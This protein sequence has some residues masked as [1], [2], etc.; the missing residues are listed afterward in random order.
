MAVKNRSR[1]E[2]EYKKPISSSAIVWR[3]NFSLGA[4]HLMLNLYLIFLL[5]LFFLPANP[6]WG[7]TALLVAALSNPFWSLIH[8]AV[9][10]M[11]H[12]SH[13]INMAAG[14]ILGIF[15]GGP[16]LV[17]RT[18]HL[19][20]H[21]LN[22]SPLEGTELYDPAQTS[23][24]RAGVGYYFQILSGLYLLE[25][26]SSLFFLLPRTI[27]LRMQERLNRKKSLSG[28][29]L[30]SLMRN[31]L[32]SE[33]R[34]DGIAILVLLGLSAFCYGKHWPWLVGALILRA[35]LI[36]FLDNVYH[37][38]TPVDDVFYA[39]NLWLP[40]GLSNVLL[41]F[42]LHGVHHGNTSIPWIELP[43]VFR[44]QSKSYDGNY[45]IAAGRQLSGP[46]PLSDLSG[47]HS[48]AT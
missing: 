1:R 26:L 9:H 30:G 32:I 6:W 34:R 48:G 36:S 19:L 2:P 10:D 20:H 39:D 28:V 5:P 16:F 46:I 37:Y 14:R 17:L 42:N 3:V 41:H 23:K 21:K 44:L 11:L 22:R 43:E 35:F 47:L 25:F 24:V 27:L 33:I 18:S 13:R 40:P 15:F 7:F 31:E 12:P 29:F 45:F 4:F 38:K 8:E